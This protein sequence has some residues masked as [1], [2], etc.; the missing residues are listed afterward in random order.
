M[1]GIRSGAD[2]LEFILAGAN[3]VSVGTSIFN[4]PSAPFRIHGE[5]QSA[6]AKHGF[7]TLQQAV[8]YAHRPADTTREDPV[9]LEQSSDDDWDFISE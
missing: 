9:T 8:S 4:D 6:L 7:S 5:L 2:A 1:G 3:A